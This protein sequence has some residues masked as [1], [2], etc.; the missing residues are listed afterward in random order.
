MELV[1]WL[2]EVLDVFDYHMCLRTAYFAVALV[3][4]V[5]SRGCPLLPGTEAGTG[6]G[7]G[8]THGDALDTSEDRLRLLGATCLHI[9]SKC[10]D[11]SYIG[12]KDLAS[13]TAQQ[14]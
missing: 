6:A 4:R 3:D 2:I 14:T 5:W 12:I 9:A 13:Q 7:A 10:E 11:V 8:D 1:S